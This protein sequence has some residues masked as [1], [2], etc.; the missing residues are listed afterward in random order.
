MMKTSDY[1][2]RLF[3]DGE[4]IDNV[5]VPGDTRESSVPMVAE[6]VYS[7]TP[8]GETVTFIV[9]TSNFVHV[10]GCY[11]PN[12]IL[13][14]HENI[15]RKSTNETAASFIIF[16]CLLTAALYHLGLFLL[17]RSRKKVLLFAVSC[18]MLALLDKKWFFIFFPEYNWFVAI[19]FEYIWHF[20]TFAAL[21]LF[22]TTLYPKLL[23]RYVTRAYYALAGLY[24][25]ATLLLDSTVFTGLLLYFEIASICMILYIFIRLVMALRYKTLQTALSFV[26]VFAVGLLGLNDILYYRGIQ[27]IGPIGGKFYGAPLG[28]AFFVFCFSLALSIE[29]AETETAMLDARDKERALTAENAALDRTN[30]MKTDLMATISH[31]TRTPL[32][33]LSGYVELIAM[34]LRERDITDQIAADLDEITYEIQ[35]IGG[36]MEETQK[37]SREKD[38]T[39]QREWVQIEKIIRQATRLYT[40]ILARKKTALTLN[41]AEGLPPLFVNASEL[42][43]VLFNILQ[44]ARNHTKNGN[45][46][47]ESGELKDETGDSKIFVTVADTGS[48][49]DPELL[50]HVFERDVHGNA[51]DTEG[52]GLGLFIC[53]E[54]IEGH[55]GEID[56]VSEPGKGTRVTIT[57]PIENTEK[58]GER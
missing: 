27:L 55:G 21:T 19:R 38:G 50:P 18:L 51:G 14:S 28:M 31:E 54:I 1:A 47:I 42:T 12:L 40:P 3:I 8:E 37:L 25:L 20:A 2:M 36:I 7:F 15:I 56:V 57:L 49:I 17:N 5:G 34:E 22:L 48:G 43:Q 24:V 4:E 46:R 16:G 9:Q 41:L 29:Y 39:R 44:N 32:A 30:R 45:V 23:H 10:D 6:R 26:G 35:R 33:V 53:K 11:A 58:V 13:G 52:M